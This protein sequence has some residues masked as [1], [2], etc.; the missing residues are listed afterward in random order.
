[1]RQSP[2]VFDYGTVTSMKLFKIAI[3]AQ[4]SSPTITEQLAPLLR[5]RGHTVD[6]LDLSAIP[7]KNFISDPL[8]QTLPNYDLVYYRSGLESDLSSSFNSNYSENLITQLET[9]LSS[10]QVKTVNLHYSKHPLAN[11]KSYETQ[12]AEKYGLLV[13][14][15]LYETTE[16]FSAIAESLGQPLVVKT[17]IGTNGNGVFLIENTDEL[18]KMRS[19]NESQQL[20]YQAF[21][22]HDFEYRVHVMAGEALCIWKKAPP[23]GDFRSNEAQGGAMLTAETE[24]T[25]ELTHLAKKVFAIFE[26]D[27]FVADFMLS[28]ET[29]EFYFTEINLNPG[30]GQPDYD[31]TGVDV[32]KLTADYFE[33]ICT[34]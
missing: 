8:I 25:N 11:S 29:G 23:D 26:F 1:M 34:E 28:K 9:F 10:H 24:H 22:P 18:S 17:D 2:V 15:T 31:A 21:I 16:D 33:T 4:L 3:F 27:I 7:T 12:Q 20:L 14:K 6:V 19:S 30:W 5:Q 32:I 13:P